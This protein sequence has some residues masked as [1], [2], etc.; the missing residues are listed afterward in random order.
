MGIGADFKEA[1][2]EPGNWTM[3]ITGFGETLPYHDNKITLDKSKKD[4]WGLPILAIDAE[5]KENE[6]KMRK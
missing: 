5:I 6:I 3:S 4:K 1:L 2:T